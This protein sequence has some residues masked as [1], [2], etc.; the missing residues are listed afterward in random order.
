M[1]VSWAKEGCQLPAVF[2]LGLANKLLKPKLVH[3]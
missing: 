2:S 1:T 3:E